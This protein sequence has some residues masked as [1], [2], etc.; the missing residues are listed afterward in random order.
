VKIVLKDPHE[1]PTLVGDISQQTAAVRP[2]VVLRSILAPTAYPLLDAAG[3]EAIQC[4]P[5]EWFHEVAVR[6]AHHP[7]LVAWACGDAQRRRSH[8]FGRRCISCP[9]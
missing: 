5:D 2:V 1:L 3:I 4:L 9:G 7:S 6:L 8:P